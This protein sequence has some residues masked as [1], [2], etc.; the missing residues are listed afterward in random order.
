MSRYNIAI[1]GMGCVFPKANN[2]NQYWKN[3]Q[4]GDTFFSRMPRDLWRMESFWSEKKGNPRKSYTEVGSFIEDFEFPFLEYKL[5]PNALKGVDPAQLV[6]LEAVREA[7]RDAGIEPRSPQLSEAATIIGSSGVDAFAHSTIFLKRHD[8]WAQVRPRLEAQGVPADVIDELFEQFTRDLLERGHIWNP[9]LASVGSIASSISNRVAQVF[10]LRGFNMTV[11]GACASSLVAVDNACH[12]LMAG[13]AR[14]VVAGGTDLGTNPSIYIG[15]C[16]VDGLSLSGMSNPF[17]NTAD[18]LVIGEG[19]G[20]VVLK[21]LEDALADGDRI[22]GVIRGLGGSSDGAGQAIYAPSVSGRVE[23]LMR[24]LK[25]AE[26]HPA[27]VQYLEAHATSTVVGDANEYDAISTVYAAGRDSVKPLRLGSVKHQIGHLKAAA[28]VAGLIKTVLALEAGVFPHMPR[29]KNLTAGAEKVSDSLLVP[30]EMAPWPRNADGRR[31]AAVTANG[32]GGVNYHA[33]VEQAESYEAPPPRTVPDRAVAIVG[34]EC[35]VAGADNV[36]TWWHNVTNGVDTFSKVDPKEVGWEYH[37][38]AGPDNERITTRVISKLEDYNFNALRYKIFP[39]AISQISPTQLLGVEIGDRLLQSA[40]FD[41]AEPKNIGVSIG[42]MHDDHFPTIWPPMV[43]DEWAA[44]LKGCSAS[45][46][47]DAAVLDQILAEADQGIVDSHPPV[48]EHTLPGWM[49]NC[50]AGRMANKL[51]LQGPNFSVDTAC[52]SGI[53]SLVPAIYQLMFGNVDMVISGGLNRQLS[54]TFTCGVCAL[55][56]VAEETPRPF[57][58]KGAGF[59]IGEGG[60]FYLLKRLADAQRDGDTIYAVLDAVSGSSEADS[61][62]MVAPSEEAMTRSIRSTLAKATVRPEEIGVVDTHGSANPASDVVEAR[63]LAAELRRNNG[64]PPVQITA[65]KSHQG[66]LYGGSGATSLLSTIMSLRTRNVPGIRNLETVRAEIAELSSRVEPRK[67]TKPLANAFTAGGVNSIGLGGANYFAIVRLPDSARPAQPSPEPLP[68]SES[69]RAPPRPVRAPRVGDIDTHD[70]F[71]CLTE[72]EDELAIALD[73]ALESSPI[74]EIISEGSTIKAKLAVTY[75]S[76][77]RLRSKLERTQMMLK[78]GR[79]LGPLESQGVYAAAVAPGA[80]PDRLAFSFPGQGVQY[81]GMG[82]HLYDRDPVFRAVVDQ[83]QDL[84]KKVFDFDLMGHIYGDIDDPEIK[85]N[86]GT[87]VGA[88]ISVFAIELA[89]AEVLKSRGVSPS[90]LIGQSFGEISALTFAGVWDLETAFEVV[91]ARINAAETINRSGGPALGMMS[92]VC[93][94]EQRD[95]ILGLIGE[96]VVLTNINAPSRFILSGQLEAIKKTVAVAESFGAEARHLP[97][98]GAFHS[99]FMEPAKPSYREALLRLPCR[100]PSIP[101][102]STITG[103]YL[104]PKRWTSE[105]VAEL[106]TSQ[107]TTKVNL[108]RDFRRLHDDG[109]RDFLEIGPGWSLTKMIRTILEGRKHRAAPTLH[110]KVGDEETFRRARAFLMALGHLESTVEREARPNMFSPEF[111]QYVELYEPAILSL[112]EEVHLRFADQIQLD[113]GSVPQIAAPQPAQLEPPRE[114]R[115]AQPQPAPAPAEPTPPVPVPAPPAVAPAAPAAPA[116]EPNDVDADVWID[117]VRGKLVEV[118]GYPSEM[119]ET[120]LDLEADL[121]V[122]SVQRAEIWTSL[123]A[124]FNLDAEAR[125]T[126]IRTIAQLAESLAQLAAASGRGAPAA[127]PA[128]PAPAAPAPVPAAPAPAAPAPAAAIVD[129]DAWV[130][131]VRDKL[132]EVTGYPPEMLES[133]LD[134][135]ADLGVDSVQRAEIWVSITASHNLKTDARPTGVKTISQLAEALA[136]LAGEG[137]DPTPAAPAP[138]APVPAAPVPAAPAPA[139][140]APAAPAPAAPAP[141]A[142]ASAGQATGSSAVDREVWVERVR[143]RLVDVTGYPSEMLEAEL[144]LEADLGVD[145]VQRAEIWVSLTSAFSLNADSRPN[146]VRTISQL[147]DSLAELAAGA[148]EHDTEAT[149]PAPDPSAAADF[150]AEQAEQ[151]ILFVPSSEPLEREAVKRFACHRVLL[152]AKDRSETAQQLIQ[153]LSRRGIDASVIRPHRV[154]ALQDADLEALLRGRDTLIYLA[155]EGLEEQPVQGTTLRIALDRAWREL[156]SVFRRM[157]P[158]LQRTPLRI[159][160]PTSQ[161]GAFGASPYGKRRLLGAFPAG[162]CRSLVRELP[163]CRFQLL[164]SGD[165]DWVTTLERHIGLISDRLE[166]GLRGGMRMQPTLARMAPPREKRQILSAGDLVL[167]TGGARGIVFECV[168]AMAERTRCSLFLTGRTPLV[169]GSPSWLS[170]TPER[171][172]DVIRDL[173]IQLVRSEGLP[174]G[175]AKNRGRVA[176]AQW[177]LNRNVESVRALGVDVRYEVCDV[178]DV[179]DFGRLI[180]RTLETEVIRGVVLGA[181]VQKARLLTDLVDDDVARTIDTKIGPLFTLLDHLDWSQARA[182]LAFSSVT[183]VFGNAGQTDY[184]LAN[185][186]LASTVKE[187]GAMYPH[188]LAQSIDWTAWAGTGMVSGEELKRFEQA[189]LVPLGVERGVE[190]FLEA[191]EGSA[192]RRLSAFNASAAFASNRKLEEHAAAARPRASLVEA[193]DESGSAQC[194][195][196]SLTRDPYLKQHLVNGEP[197]VPGTFITEIFAEVAREQGLTPAEVKFRRPLQL[198][199]PELEVEVLRDGVSLTILPS[200]R[201]LLEQ[202]ALANLAFST[203]KLVEPGPSEGAALELEGSYLDA[204]AGADALSGLSFY[205]LL[206]Q[207]FGKVLKTGPVFRGI[208]ATVRSGDYFL[209]R[210]SLTDDAM[211][212]LQIP[213]K[214]VMNPVLADMAVQVVAAMAMQKH[215]VMAIPFEIGSL[216]IGGPTPGSEAIVICQTLDLT[217]DETVVNLAVRDLEGQ[218]IFAMDRLVCKAIARAGM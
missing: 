171:I 58:T 186:M 135:E 209:G 80:P 109:V 173:E 4:S 75:R 90:V 47:I 214:F 21:R 199:G 43:V 89:V 130:E 34:M 127:A 30:N 116:T 19:G 71:V 157:M 139:A 87:L 3:I 145:S 188:L 181:G 107:L 125:P 66:H 203:C 13:D 190:L 187:I 134:L 155:H 131:R 46:K 2:V 8:F 129:K 82:Q 103:D 15:F 65:I 185:D 95:A 6:T 39:R 210:V 149:S 132:V 37:L 7:L 154:A 166:I 124:A 28:G 111:F 60:V 142:P 23:A 206:D 25:N 14:I 215:R 212:L 64:V 178:A 204:L 91:R 184:G 123:T 72:R 56:A 78:S 189:G 207:N 67:G 102:L 52:S 74:P 104:E 218:L 94:E 54:D 27:E 84:A 165:E 121:G 70:I 16:R 110:P 101:V 68:T 193:C 147:A 31:V 105:F 112:L 51:N 17:D 152:V 150:E 191:M 42:A 136:E 208:Q 62:S 44:T 97:I 164:D 160:V 120:E 169:E 35:R 217:A 158:Q 9:A 183:G 115:A 196:F 11:D 83:V 128:T 195:F 122:D 93:S 126:G 85:K 98:G 205:G 163:D 10:G 192:H 5:P 180:K 177:E 63:S 176:R 106:L 48:T 114:S 96:S 108:V 172:D 117:R 41:L 156:Y 88:Q 24:G 151:C 113:G 61:K 197:V 76:Q 22:R 118:T 179:E 119:L 198:R 38:D 73:R 137:G 77:D 146:K 18:G 175:E 201:P 81:I 194:V 59:L 159:M 148:G 92:L 211:A 162:F 140:P 100:E 20:V 45:N 29:F 49:T 69:R 143:A 167:V 153:A 79:G 200:D 55:G 170:S 32:F 33:I 133:D 1:I 138:A 202:K 141:A 213:G 53:A 182:L 144:D 161:D 36:D 50:T 40:G 168:K 216:H 12:A 174:L 86:L 57:D 26:T 99:H